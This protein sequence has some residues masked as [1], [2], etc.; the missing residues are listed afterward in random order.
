M[1]FSSLW[2][3]ACHSSILTICGVIY[4]PN[5]CVMILIEKLLF[6]FT[7]LSFTLLLIHISDI[8]LTWRYCWFLILQFQITMIKWIWKN[9]NQIFCF[10]VYIKLC[11]LYTIVYIESP[12][13]YK[14]IQPVNPKGNHPEYS[15]EGLMLKL[16]LQYFGHLMRRTDSLEKTLK[17]GKIEGRKRMGRQSMRWLDGITKSIDMSLSK[18]FISPSPGV[19]DRQGSLACC[20]PWGCKESDM[21]EWLNWYWTD[22]LLSVQYH[23]V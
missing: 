11:L 9:V 23:Y 19:G 14:Q 16:K 22:S 18:E 3:Y 13:D 17:L 4:T 7:D 12:L 15:L 21:T 1:S 6:L 8:Y 5:A 2:L 10:P 20:I